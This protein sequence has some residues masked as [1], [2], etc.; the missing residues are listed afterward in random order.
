MHIEDIARA[1]MIALTAPRELVHDQVF[2]IGSTSANYQMRELAEIVAET[3]PGCRVG[4]AP[5]ASP[6]PATTG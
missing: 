3:V 5:G 6:D 1:F 4:F 2:N